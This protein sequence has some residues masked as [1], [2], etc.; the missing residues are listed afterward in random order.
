MFLRIGLSKQKVLW[1][2]SPIGTVLA[3]FVDSAGDYFSRYHLRIFVVTLL[4][5]QTRAKGI[6]VDVNV[7]VTYYLA[8]V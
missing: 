4:L 6:Q 2:T 8:I 7:N 3:E 1:G 5:I